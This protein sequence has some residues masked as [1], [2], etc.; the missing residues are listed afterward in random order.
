MALS[1]PY[2]RPRTA[3]DHP[4]NGIRN[5]VWLAIET[6]DG[7]TGWG[8]AYCGCYATEV[9]LAA[10]RRLTAHLAGGGMTDVPAALDE[11]RYR[12][13]Y[14]AMRGIGAQASS[15]VEGALY[16]LAAQEAGVPLWKLLGGGEPRPVMP[17]A[18]AGEGRFTPEEVFE[19]A[20]YFA[21]AGY[22]AYKM[23]CGGYRL[24]PP[25]PAQLGRDAERVAAAREALGP[26]RL[27][28]VDVAMP[29]RPTPWPRDHVAAYLE[30]LARYAVR[31]LEEP[32]LTYDVAGYRELQSMG[33]VPV[34]GGESFSCPEEFEPFFE[35][36]AYGVAQPDA[37]VVGGPASCAA[38]ARRAAGCG[39]PV[40]LHS[41]PAAAGI[42]QNLHAGWASENILAIEWPQ[43]S[44][45]LASE[46]LDPIY[47]WQ[48]GWLLP[49][50]EP[51][52][53]LRIP[54]EF[55]ERYAYQPGQ[56]R[57]Y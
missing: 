41:W 29:Q 42:A 48:D 49:S 8:E 37:A 51:G 35:A 18:S 36:G 25:S 14:W 7:R 28:F 31:F 50:E 40:A 17:Y 4:S 3:P 54:P 22:R 11:V 44:H 32:A 46:P 45:A 53:G 57:D 39:I 38:V 16:D 19:D 6:E 24:D 33:L 10:L 12:N 47:R 23:R 55:L 9:T 13:R 15:A 26:E 30:M 5:C 27:L 52:M 34:A 56:E 2:V 1:A 21:A 43:A 20:A